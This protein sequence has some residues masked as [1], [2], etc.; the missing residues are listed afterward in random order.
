[1]VAHPVAHG[2]GNSFPSGHS[3]GSVVCYGAVLLAF[4]PATR[5]RWR[6]AFTAGILTLAALIGISRILLGVH[7]ISDVRG[8]LGARHHLARR[9]RPRL[10]AD[11][12]AAGQPVTEPVTEGLEPEARADLQPTEPEAALRS[13]PAPGPPRTGRVA[14]GVVVAWVLIVGVIVGVGKLIWSPATGTGTCS[15]TGPGRTGSPPTG[16]P[17]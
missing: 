5:G 8:R 2:T 3:L 6:R 14:A 10:R 16:P 13:V 4:L 7:Y 11:P 9:H 12:Q 17:A 15:A 1:M